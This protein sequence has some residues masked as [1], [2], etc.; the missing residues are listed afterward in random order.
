M[1]LRIARTVMVEGDGI[2]LD[3]LIFEAMGREDLVPVVLDANPGLAALGPI[4]PVGTR[5]CIPEPDASEAITVI[6]T[7]KLWDE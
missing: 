6:P 5:V 7:V 1:S 3:R 4:L 2:A